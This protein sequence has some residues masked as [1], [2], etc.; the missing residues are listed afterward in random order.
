MISKKSIAMMLV[1][2]IGIS[3]TIAVHFGLMVISVDEIDMDLT[4]GEKLRINSDT[5]ALHFG[6]LVPGAT[7]NRSIK[8]TN[9]NGFPVVVMIKNTGNIKD[10]IRMESNQLTIEAG[11]NA[12]I[13]YAAVAPADA[14]FGHYFGTSEILIK[15]QI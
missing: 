1:I 11:G 9:E 15:R 13:L 10:Y 14:D 6:S 2:L 12:S 3:A 7:A 8:V 4:I 5:D